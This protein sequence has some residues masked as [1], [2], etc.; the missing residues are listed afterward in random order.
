MAEHV[1]GRRQVL[2]GA[3]VAAGGAAVGAVAFAGPA[4]A[5]PEGHGGHGKLSGS[6]LIVR[7]DD[8]T[9]TTTTGVLSFAAGNVMIEHDINPAGPP[10]SGT[11]EGHDGRLKATLWSGASGNGPNQPGPTLRVRLRGQVRRGNLTGTYT[12]TAFDPTT[13][14]PVQSGSGK[15]LRGHFIEP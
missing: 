14:A 4:S 12:F 1:I 5:S 2:R 13:G 9:T 10:F 15:V 11:W 3:G 7:Q 6:W 8:G